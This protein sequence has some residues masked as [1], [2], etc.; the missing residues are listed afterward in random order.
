[1][2]ALLDGRRTVLELGQAAQLSEFD[3]TKVVFRLL[4]GGF[5]PLSDKPLAAGA[6]P[7]AAGAE[8]PWQPVRAATAP[9]AAR[10]ARL[11]RAARRRWMRARGGARL[12]PHLPGDPRRGGQAGHGPRV[13]RLGQRGA[14]GPGAVAPRRCWRGWPSRRTAAC[15]RAGW[16]RPSS[17]T[18]TRWAREPLASF[19]QALSDVMFFLL[20]QAG[21]LLESRADEDLARRVKELLATLEAP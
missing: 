2:L 20:F 11:A 6:P 12:Q 16:S 18:A 14:L 10:R 9:G 19:R 1:M 15:P 4:E 21:E 5:A 17:A 7:P 13:H 3:V 8:D